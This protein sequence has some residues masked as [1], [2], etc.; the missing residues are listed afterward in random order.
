MCLFN[1]GSCIEHAEEMTEGNML[2]V[3]V[4]IRLLSGRDPCRKYTCYGTKDFI[5]H[6]G[7]R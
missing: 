2:A 6:L 7:N 3:Y 5:P 1:Q 4:G